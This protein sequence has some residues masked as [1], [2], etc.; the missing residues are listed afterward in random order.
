SL[1][2]TSR[3]VTVS[4]TLQTRAS[5]SPV[6]TSSMAAALRRAGAARRADMRWSTRS[7]VI[8]TWTVLYPP[9]PA[10]LEN[11]REDLKTQN[12]R[13]M[14]G[15]GFGGEAM[16]VQDFFGS[17][18]SKYFSGVLRNFFSQGLQQILISW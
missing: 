4:Q 3:T 16:C 5:L 15:A 11:P 14:M 18:F 1:V 9:Y 8:V 6:L 7:E 13:S 12:P 10:R 2:V 17:S